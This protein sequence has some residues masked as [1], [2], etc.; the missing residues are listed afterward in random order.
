MRA[1]S[2]MVET[3]QD[4]DSALNTNKIKWQQMIYKGSNEIQ[5]DE[6]LTDVGIQDI[7]E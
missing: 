6:V 1:F 5:I 2:Q 3:G 7:I 4:E